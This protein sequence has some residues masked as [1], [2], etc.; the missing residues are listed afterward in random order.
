MKTEK[1]DMHV[2]LQDKTGVFISSLAKEYKGLINNYNIV[3][4]KV[5]DVKEAKLSVL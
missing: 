4:Y 1:S 3:R 2:I 5:K